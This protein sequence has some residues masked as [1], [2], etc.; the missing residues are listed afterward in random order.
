MVVITLRQRRV[1]R[2]P[3]RASR[4]PTATTS[5]ARCSA[6][7]AWSP[8]ATARGQRCG[9]TPRPE[10]RTT[11]ARSDIELLLDA[12]AGEF[13]EF[14]A[15]VREGRQPVGHR[16]ATRAGRWP[17]ALACIESVQTHAPVARADR[18][19]RCR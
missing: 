13:V 19:R 4:P 15:A 10:R 12:Y 8:S 1:A 18:P 16:R 14:A 7:G 5:A 9:S 11:T 3:R 6:R 2:S 17:I